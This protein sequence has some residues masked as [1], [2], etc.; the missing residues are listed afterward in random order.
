MPLSS[1]FFFFEEKIDKKV[2]KRENVIPFIKNFLLGRE[3]G[4][5]RK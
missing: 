5:R 2:K 3:G 4:E 1:I